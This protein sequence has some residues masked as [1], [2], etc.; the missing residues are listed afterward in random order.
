V[1]EYL[2]VLERRIA[3]MTNGRGNRV[4]VGERPTVDAVGADLEG[5]IG[6]NP[7]HEDGLVPIRRDGLLALQS[8]GCDQSNPDL[9]ADAIRRHQTVVG[10][11]ELSGSNETVGRS[12]LRPLPRCTGK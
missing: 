8:R 12:G 4:D 9:R 5:P 2:Y 1:A 11:K 7:G 10:W 6:G 3:A